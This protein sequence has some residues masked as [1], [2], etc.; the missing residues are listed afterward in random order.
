MVNSDDS[1]FFQG[2][3]ADILLNDVKIG[4]FGVLHPEV[5]QKFEIA[6]PCSALEINLEALLPIHL[7]H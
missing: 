3:R 7:K 5:L 2:R 1:T 6:N 4:V